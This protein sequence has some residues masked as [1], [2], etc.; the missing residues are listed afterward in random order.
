ML[1]QIWART[2]S[3]HSRPLLLVTIYIIASVSATFSLSFAQTKFASAAT[4]TEQAFCIQTYPSGTPVLLNGI[5]MTAN[6]GYTK[7]HC[8]DICKTRSDSQYNG[9][10]RDIIDTCLPTTDLTPTYTNGGG[11]SPAATITS[12]PSAATD[13]IIIDGYTTALTS[14]LCGS[15]QTCVTKVTDA[16]KYCLQQ[17]MA[18]GY[19]SGTVVYPAIDTSVVSS[20]VASRSGTSALE[21]KNALDKVSD[22]VTKD[23]TG[24]ISTTNKDT[25]VKNGGV[26]N[27][28]T[29]QCDEKASTCI[30][31]GI[32]WIVCPVM[33]FV[34]EINDK[35]SE[36]ISQLLSFDGSILQTGNANTN[37]TATYKAWSEFRNIANVAFVIAFV[38]IILSQVSSIGVSNYGIKRLFPKLLI[39]AILVNLSFI[40]CSLFVDISNV[41]GYG[42][43]GMMD[44]ILQSITG[45]SNP[46]TILWKDTIS[47][48]LAGG[49]LAAGTAGVT[50]AAILT[51]GGMGLIALATP[52]ILAALLALL[53]IVII[54]VARQAL[55][56]LLVVVAPLAFV[57]YLL[58]NTEQWYKK[59]QKLFLTLLMLFPIVSFVFSGSR[60][61]SRIIASLGGGWVIVALG[62]ESIPLFVV[63]GLLKGSLVAAG[64]LGTKLQGLGNKATGRIGQEVKGRYSKSNFGQAAKMR[65]A[66]R[67]KFQRTQL[68]NRIGQGDATSRLLRGYFPG[69]KAAAGR[70]Y[71]NNSAQAQVSKDEKEEI[72]NRIVSM[73]KQDGWTVHN[74]Q[75]MA[76]KAF[77]ESMKSGD[78]V[79]AR[80]AQQIMLSGGGKG[81]EELQ[82]AYTDLGGAANYSTIMSGSGQKVLSDLN[83]AGLKGKNAAL[84]K[85]AYSDP[86]KAENRVQNIANDPSTYTALTDAELAGQSERNII[87][88]NISQQRAREIQ[89]NNNVWQNLSEEK[90]NIIRARILQP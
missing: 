4:S 43:K 16:S 90:K 64:T 33:N 9:G 1:N 13:K 10:A 60:L 47:K 37:K 3:I 70:D 63:P 25:C 17:F 26:W 19:D 36:M 55:I 71:L 28:S 14:K 77:V 49:A 38:V 40:I 30:I 41:L 48:L 18:N 61:A 87:N 32:G 80:A 74:T 50:I 68:A 57:A 88:A 39:S 35:M 6:S 46:P 20:C 45:A 8:G 12:S 65:E 53:M 15:N 78:V 5:D 42:V 82:N 23:A 59:W 22:Q 51:E 52:I 56:I 31:T 66:G 2:R 79:S 83:S 58:P 89:N 73:Q 7:N 21:A 86:T 44:A 54:L 69:K 84:A 11:S 67:E 81:V 24:V 29:N 34:A 75:K 72:D 85:L 76:R 62:V 27:T